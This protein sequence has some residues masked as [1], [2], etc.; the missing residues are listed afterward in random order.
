M[1]N[2]MNFAL[3]A[4]A[5]F[6][7]SAVN[8]ATISPEVSSLIQSS[9]P[10][11]KISVIVTLKAKADLSTINENNKSKRREKILNALK[12]NANTSQKS[13]TAWLKAD[14]DVAGWKL[15]WMINAV[16]TELPA[17]KIHQ[18]AKRDDVDTITLDAKIKVQ[19]ESAGTPTT[20]E[21]NL[22]A[23]NA[24]DLWD[25]GVTGQGVVIA[26]MDTGVDN[27]HS[28]LASKWR[29]GDNSWYD[30]HGVYELPH[31]SNGHGT[32]TTGLVV[33]GDA[34][35]STIGVA[36]DA[37]WIAVKIFDDADSSTLSVIHQGFQWLLDPDND[38][39]TD[40]APDIVSNAWNIQTSLNSCNTEFQNDINI[41][42]QSDIAV[43][44]SAG[45]AGPYSST[46]LSPANNEGSIA[47]GAVDETLTV[48]YFSSRGPS[49]CSGGLYP[50]V[51]APGMNVKTSDLTFGGAIPNSYAYKSGT[52]FAVPHLAG[53]MALLK[54]S[55]SLLTVSELESA[56]QQSSVDAGVVGDD[57]DYG[58]GL[59]DV[60]A[61]H[62][63]LNT[64]SGGGTLPVDS[65]G[66]G[67][68]SDLD[69]NDNDA[70]VYPGA[71][72]TKH[73]GI[74]QDCNGYDLTIE[75]TKAQYSAK[76]DSLS[77]TATSALGKEANLVVDGLG[78]MNWS[79]RKAHWS[80]SARKIGGNP[81]IITISGKEGDDSEVVTVK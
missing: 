15:L 37:Q 41:L 59:L 35:G 67:V 57:N 19:A 24:N 48:G 58:W 52:S 5:V 74:D 64:G 6:V 21:W 10:S 38:A 68:T 65:D 32:Q 56:I 42:R 9:N 23:I 28:D 77:V 54:S 76:R 73:D 1:F 81:E 39:A 50:Q 44:F 31:D 33:G 25:Q 60:A 78:A 30:P 46:S 18:L 3:T 22:Q 63:S 16:A 12:N 11:D 17:G 27:L 13:L 7:S 72:E 80:L 45:N 20:A 70:S 29:G 36:P 4:I 62:A 26:S 75:I 66:D 43:V 55:N 69:C 51:A 47:T 79:K 34:S 8:A 2:K 40:D 71:F 53:A 14:K 61:A 49:A